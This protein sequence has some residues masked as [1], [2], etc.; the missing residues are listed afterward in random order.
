MTIANLGANALGHL[1]T[2]PPDW[3]G[4]VLVALAVIHRYYHRF[5]ANP[6]DGFYLD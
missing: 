6:G 3:P 4:G 2:L 1:A 5:C